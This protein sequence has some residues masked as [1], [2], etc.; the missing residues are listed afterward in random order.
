M[1]S[2]MEPAAAKSQPY[3]VS[4]AN[5]T[6]GLRASLPIDK[7]RSPA[8]TS[9]TTKAS[10]D[11]VLSTSDTSI[12][13][14][15]ALVTWQKYFRSTWKKHLLMLVN[16]CHMQARKRLQSFVPFRSAIKVADGVLPEPCCHLVLEGTGGTTGRARTTSTSFNPWA[17]RYN[18][19]H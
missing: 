14:N 4:T 17:A 19:S 11:R 6:S 18:T 2:M 3:A 9:L 8:L 1:Q 15:F 5:V 10:S 16:G 13:G 12:S 7:S